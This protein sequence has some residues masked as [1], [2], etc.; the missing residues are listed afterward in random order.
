VVDTELTP[1]V[2]NSTGVSHLSTHEAEK[3]AYQVEQLCD[4]DVSRKESLLR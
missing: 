1:L 2:D 4:F 3:L